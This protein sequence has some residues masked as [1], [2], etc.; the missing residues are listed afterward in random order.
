MMVCLPNTAPSSVVPGSILP[1][2]DHNHLASVSAA[3]PLDLG[4]V[5]ISWNVRALVLDALRTLYDDLAATGLTY[6]VVVVDSASSDGSAEAV[7][8]AFPQTDVI[9]LAENVGFG[10][11]NNVGLRAL[12]FSTSPAS[13]AALPR[14]AYLLNPD[15]R[16]KP[17]A[18]RR[19][20]DTLFADAKTGLVGARLQYGDGQFQHSA[21]AFP[22]LRQLW[23]EL[24]P[25]PG[26]LLESGFNGRY[27][28]ACYAGDAPFGVDF[29]LGATMMLRA[30]TVQQTA[31]YNAAT[32]SVN[33]FD[34]AYFMY[35]EEID[36]AW[37]IHRAGWQVLCEP[38]ADVVHLGGQSTGQARPESVLHLWESRLRLYRRIHPAWKFALTQRMIARGMQGKVKTA[39][40]PELKSAYQTIAAQAMNAT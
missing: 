6:R 18:T 21:F 25:T 19:L 23:A 32:Q 9:A 39:P 40:T 28:R 24:F 16:T 34:E 15:T 11:A 35:C 17:G 1:G 27:P 20:Y 14:A 5:V 33:F 26:R 8:A 2:W 38:R 3:A 30:E 13:S 4:V 29:V 22:G 12:G 37:R 10:A 36:W 7:R 31:F